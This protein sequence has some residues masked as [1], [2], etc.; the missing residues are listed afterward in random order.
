MIMVQAPQCQVALMTA[1]P[2]A[3]PATNVQAM[4]A[5]RATG[6]IWVAVLKRDPHAPGLPEQ[7]GMPRPVG[8][9]L[10]AG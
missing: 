9:E 5:V 2:C 6:L 7:S 1:L 3:C 8:G 10:H 4:G